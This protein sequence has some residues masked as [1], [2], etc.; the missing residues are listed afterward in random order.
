MSPARVV[1]ARRAGLARKDLDLLSDAALAGKAREWLEVTAA[2]DDAA[3]RAEADLH[4]AIGGL[5]DRARRREL[6]ALRRGI[7]S[8]VVAER[9]EGV[10]RREADGLESVAAWRSARARRDELAN[11]PTP[12]VLQ[13]PLAQGVAELLGDP[14]FL[15]GLAI[16]SPAFAAEVMAVQRGRTPSNGA[17]FVRS[18]LRYLSRAAHKPSPFSTL[19]T[20]HG[21]LPESGGGQV[22]AQPGVSQERTTF[23]PLAVELFHALLSIPDIWASDRAPTVGEP[24]TA[25][26]AGATVGLLP[27][28]ACRDGLFYRSDELTELTEEVLP[29]TAMDRVAVGR[30]LVQKPWAITEIG[31]LQS[32]ASWA[33]DRLSG[34][35]VE[36][37]QAL[38]TWES[39]FTRAESPREIVSCLTGLTSAARDAFDELQRPAP[40]WLRTE[41]LGHESVAG[42][43]VAADTAVEHVLTAAAPVM[44]ARTRLVPLYTHLMAL[45]DAR[46]GDR[47]VGLLEFAIEAL[48]ALD[49]AAYTGRPPAT[50]PPP[51]GLGSLLRPASVAY[52]QDSSAGVVV[53]SL[54]ADFLG[55]RSRWARL[56]QVRAAVTVDAVETARWRAPDTVAYA[57]TASGDWT[58]TQRPNE[59]LPL[60]AWGPELLDSP[61]AVDLSRFTVRLERA[62]HTIQIEDLR[63]RAASLHY[64][65]AIPPHLLVG[66]EGILCTISAPWFI[67]PISVAATGC[68]HE[69]REGEVAPRV[70]G[71]GV[72]WARRTWTIPEPAPSG[73]SSVDLRWSPPRWRTGDQ[74]VPF[75]ADVER[76]RQRHGIPEEFFVRRQPAPSVL[77]GK[78][79][80]VSVEHPLTVCAAFDAGARGGLVVTEGLPASTDPRSTLGDGHV[81]EFQAV[82]Q[83]G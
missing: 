59:I 1:L 53:N 52:V 22:T 77:P 54:Q 80:W 74:V 55:S 66:V 61:A 36:I 23:R 14:A 9:L 27:H 70:V 73:T 56:E 83:H 64:V 68:G 75:L 15:H 81:V 3:D 82:V 32:L 76:W 12:N 10:L 31:E 37:L 18:A 2:L 26:V 13:G 58:A 4:A 51:R 48:T 42:P 16:A 72:V 24:A 5:Q 45:L 43:L 17:R 78:P 67:A 60:A 25:R 46:H 63:G 7:H 11:L 41:S 71:A 39:E 19:A 57:F 29:E 69:G 47:R 49:Q 20:L 8:G 79:T 50:Q 65:G 62:S 30:A 38:S 28:Y 6:L 40:S 33:Q 44:A 21:V 34:P 35:I